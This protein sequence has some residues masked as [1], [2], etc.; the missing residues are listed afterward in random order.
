MS[1]KFE[2]S[3]EVLNLLGRGLYRSFATVIAEA[4]SNSW[5]AGATEVHIFIDKDKREM[6]IRDNGKGM[7]KDDF[8][9]KFLKV[10]Y[11][12]REDP[13]NQS[14][15]KALGRKGIGKLALL[16]ISDKITITSKKVDSE[17]TGGVIDNHKLD[18]KI[19]TDGEYSLESLSEDSIFSKNTSGT[20]LKF[21]KIKDTVNNPDIIKKYLAVL[22]NFSIS[23]NSETFNIYVNEEQI[24]EKHLEDLHNNTQFLWCIDMETENPRLDSLKLKNPF[25]LEGKTFIHDEI[26]HH[27]KGYVASVYKPNQLKIHGTGGDFKAGLHLF[28]NGRLRQEDIFKDITSHRVVESYLYGE[29]HVDAFDEGEDIFTSSREGII[30]DNPRYKKFLEKLKEIQKKVLDDWDKWRKKENEKKIDETKILDGMKPKKKKAIEK[31]LSL[32]EDDSLKEKFR[33]EFLPALLPKKIEK[34]ILISHS[35]EDKNLADKVEKE[36][37]NRGFNSEKILYTK[38]NN[39]QSRLPANVEDIFEY[40]KSFFIQDCYYNPL[41]IFV[42][43]FAMEKS[44]FASLEAGAVWVTGTKHR[45]TTT[46]NYAP[47]SPLNIKR[48]YVRF[49]EEGKFQDP[50]EAKQVFDSIANHFN[51]DTSE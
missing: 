1:F 19:N 45:I 18:D 34:Q 22:F 31:F 20:Y 43:S 27:I 10:G 42:T 48:L 50:I 51:S 24:S 8:Q 37:L 7:D 23:N 9:G 46:H 6:I 47:Q 29:I 2:F 3:L 33:K 5:D 15:R 13:N 40:I 36:L 14:N 41:V 35:T 39:T 21:E 28:V 49:N 11:S 38:S 26:Q 25:N 16:S 4:I 17:E 30:K 44:W 12:R 32:K